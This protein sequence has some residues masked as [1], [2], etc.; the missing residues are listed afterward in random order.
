[1][2]DEPPGH[3]FWGK[4]ADKLEKAEGEKT[5]SWLCKVCNVSHKGTLGRVIE[6]FSRADGKARIDLTGVYATTKNVEG[7]PG[8]PATSAAI[9]SADRQEREKLLQ[10]ALAATQEYVDVKINR[11][12]N[13]AIEAFNGWAIML[14]CWVA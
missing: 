13:W 12:A 3:A 6:H 11:R 14:Q 10:E 2:S 7:C 4:F 1:M 5:A 8:P 9:S